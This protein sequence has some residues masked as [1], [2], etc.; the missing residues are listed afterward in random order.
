[1]R[2]KK[3]IKKIYKKTGLVLGL[4]V[5]IFLGAGCAEPDYTKKKYQI[6]ALTEDDA[7][8]ETKENSKEYAD[9]RKRIESPD[10]M[11]PSDEGD[12]EDINPKQAERVETTEYGKKIESEEE[13]AMLVIYICGAVHTPGV[14]TLEDGSRVVDAIM[15]A[16]GLTKDADTVWTNQARRLTD[17]EQIQILTMEEARIAKEQGLGTKDAKALADDTTSTPGV[18]YGKVNIN[19]ADVSTLMTLPGIGQVKAEAI[20]KYR[21][22]H[23]MFTSIMDLL[24][25]AGIKESVF[26][27]L[28]DLITI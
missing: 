5:M 15:A 16:G 8:Q 27:K 18:S 22:E 17:G 3:H 6:D 21:N 7:A 13:R 20:V 28:K 4:C 25:V 2:E 23:G 24:Y 19:E 14:Y 10:M 12:K 9:E 1:M 26:S 11:E